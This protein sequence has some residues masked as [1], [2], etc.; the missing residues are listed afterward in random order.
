MQIGSD[1]TRKPLPAE[2]SREEVPRAILDHYR[3]GCV[4]LGQ[5]HSGPSAAI[6]IFLDVLKM[7]PGFYECRMALRF[8]QGGVPPSPRPLERLFWRLHRW[9][10]LIDAQICLW[11]GKPQQALESAEQTLGIVHHSKIAHRIV[12]RA[13]AALKMPRT[14]IASWLPFVKRS[15]E[16]IQFMMPLLKSLVNSGEM[17]EASLVLDDIV[18]HLPRG[19]LHAKSYN[20][21]VALWWL[22][23]RA[24]F[25]DSARRRVNGVSREQ[26]QKAIIAHLRRQLEE[27]P[28]DGEL[29]RKLADMY[30]VTGDYK[31]AF[32]YYEWVTNKAVPTEGNPEIWGGS[33]RK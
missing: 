12:F 22:A 18:R 29:A 31:N 27:H 21:F 7:Y 13:S 19:G 3:R 23:K 32:R 5:T 10:K 30:S 8:A 17:G 11:S 20:D 1:K 14:A 28:T 33:F 16:A 9:A 2:Y 4:L 6:E 25:D 26:Q 24:Q 15:P